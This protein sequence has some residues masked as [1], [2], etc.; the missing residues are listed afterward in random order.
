M[1]V[2]V[3]LFKDSNTPLKPIQN[4]NQFSH[5]TLMVS[6]ISSRGHVN[7]LLFNASQTCTSK[8]KH[9]LRYIT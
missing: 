6:F 2:P 9:Q 7:L 4:S 3:H 1:S 8:P 5:F